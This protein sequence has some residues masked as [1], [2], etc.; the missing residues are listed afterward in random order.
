MSTEE[1]GKTMTTAVRV[2]VV[3][4]LFA[5][6]L[7]LVACGDRKAQNPTATSAQSATVAETQASLAPTITYASEP[8]PPH[9]GENAVSV[10]IRDK[11]GSPIA[12]LAVTATYFMPA[13]PSMKMPEMRDSFALTPQGEG[14][15]AG[16]VR[17]SMGGTWIV[18]V[19]AKRGEEPVA[20][21]LLSIVAKE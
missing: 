2:R 3:S 1:R 9:S 6:M 15:Y 20:R 10:L 7:T 21:K 18:T 12:D 19:T 13:M 16:A 4:V 5:S 14:K 8:D 17:L 11:D